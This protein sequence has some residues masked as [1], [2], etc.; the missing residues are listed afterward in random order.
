MLVFSVATLCLAFLAHVVIWQV[1]VPRSQIASVLAIFFLVLAG[2]LAVNRFL[3]LPAGW[4]PGT[5]WE[6]LLAVTFH[7]SLSLTYTVLYTNIQG[8]SPTLRIV[9]SIADA[10][11]GGLGRPDLEGILH[12][13]GVLLSRL[14]AMVGQGLATEQDGLLRLTPAGRQLARLYGVVDRIFGLTPGG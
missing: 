11:P 5:P 8:D 1:R 10:G 7:A 3:P 6:Y 12:E 9:A 4:G 13:E 2:A 14:R